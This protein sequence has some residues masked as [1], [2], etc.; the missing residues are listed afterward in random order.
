MALS[1]LIIPAPALAVTS[2][3]K[4][5]EADALM[6][7]LDSM[8]DEVNV[9]TSNYGDAIAAHD[10]AVE[11]MDEAQGRIDSANATIVDLQSRLSTRATAMYR[12]GSTS[13]LEVLLGAASFED[14]VITWDLL[15]ELN[16]QDAD[17]VQESKDARIEAQKAH[18]EYAA[19][20]I[21]AAD[22]LAI[23]EKTKLQLDGV[24]ASM[25]T[26]IS[27]LTAEAAELLS[28]EE[29]AAEAAEAAATAVKNVVGGNVIVGSGQY[30]HPCPAYTYISSTFGWR[31][32]DNAFHRGVDYAAPS[33]TPIY[34][35]EAGTVIVAGYSSSAG[36][37]VVISHGNGVTSK[38]MHMISTP[39]IS[40]GQYVTKGQ[41]IGGVGTTGYSTGNHLHF[42]IEINGTAV[43]P[44]DY[45]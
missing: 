20:E 21:I 10:L 24:A 1:L 11:S 34:A 31:S 37:W 7:K 36:N 44:L 4:Q 13:F 25:Q 41:N 28:Q 27:T 16:Q 9:A 2:A 17:M 38:Y 33:G 18:E 6:E 15:N 29:D 12:N 32:F 14:F 45:V 19:Q 22:Q 23:A 42:Q 30:A 35:I 5:A 26:E 8:Q 40:A 39:Y 43:D 3:E